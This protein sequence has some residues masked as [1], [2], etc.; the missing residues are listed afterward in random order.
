MI[1]C[2]SCGAEN[3]DGARF[4]VKCGAALP[5]AATHAPES[6]RAS[7]DLQSSTSGSFNNAGPY[8]PP[9][10]A[11]SPAYAS[12]LSALPGELP[13]AQWI[14]RVLAAL[15]DG[16]LVGAVMIVLYLIIGLIFGGLAAVG[17]GI[18]DNAAGNAFGALGSGICCFGLVLTPISALLI[19]IYNKVYLISKRGFSIGQGIMK[20]K[21]VDASGN[22]L[23]TGTAVLRLLVQIGLGF[24]PFVGWLLSLLNLLWPLWDDKRQTLHD[25]AVNSFVI[26]TH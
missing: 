12:A 14:D 18:G 25:K 6:W 1:A 17:S 24:I 26:K 13:Y 11:A 23:S 21:V 16:A 4:C 10:S 9:L 2:A 3:L 22:L 20:L 19:G 7:G 15:I 5:L 8:V